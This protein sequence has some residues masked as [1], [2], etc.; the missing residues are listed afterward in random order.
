M[1]QKTI[2]VTG[3]NGDIGRQV[4]IQALSQN[5]TVFAAI[6]NKAHIDTFD[7][8]KNLHFILMDMTNW[9]SIALGFAD[10]DKKLDDKALNAI[11]HCAAIAL[12][13]SVEFLSQQLFERTHKINTSGSLAIL[14]NAFPR[15]RKSRGTIVVASSVWGRVSGVMVGCYS[16]S[17]WALESLIDAS[18]RETRGMG[19]NIVSANIGAVKSSMLN[20]HTENIQNILDQA[21]AVEKSLYARLYETHMD[22]VKKFDSTAITPQ[23]VASKLLAISEARKPQTRYSI[24][25]DSKILIPLSWLLPAR[26][27]DAALRAPKAK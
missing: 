3:A 15:L 7:K 17:K 13:S 12:P 6:R 20:S 5:K 10:I 14:Q 25:I 26:W 27:L 4:V 21:G 18:R 24:G 11:I 2:L 9:N 19:F 22:Q 8:H 23:K 16:S 1:T